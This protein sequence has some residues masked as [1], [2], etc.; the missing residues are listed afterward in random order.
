MEFHTFPQPQQQPESTSADEHPDSS[1]KDV[2]TPTKKNHNQNTIL[3]Q[4]LSEEDEVRYI[5][6]LTAAFIYLYY[7]YRTKA[8]SEVL[9]FFDVCRL[10]FG[11]FRFCTH[12]I[13]V[14]RP[15]DTCV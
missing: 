12:S 9:N 10:F 6:I 5:I 15:L 14:N 11:L 3:K 7:S 1:S 4:L 8:K 2:T 13:V